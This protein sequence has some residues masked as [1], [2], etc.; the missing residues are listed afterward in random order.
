VPETKPLPLRLSRRC[1]WVKPQ[2]GA[3]DQKRFL[4][5]SAERPPRPLRAARALYLFL[6]LVRDRE[7]DLVL[8]D[9]GVENLVIEE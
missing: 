4:W 3:G 2:V 6:G 9:A 5:A 8:L 7:R 1:S